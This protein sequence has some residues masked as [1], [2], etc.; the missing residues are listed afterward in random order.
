MTAASQR[1][2]QTIAPYFFVGDIIRAAEYYR[3]K[4]G[5]AFDRYWGDPPGFVIVYR[6][7]VHV[8]LRAGHDGGR[9][10]PNRTLDEHAWDAYIWVRDANAMHEELKGRLAMIT[11]SPNDTFYGC[12]EFE[13]CDLDGHIICF[14]QVLENAGS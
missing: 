1:D 9:P 2:L 11:R 4:L 5:F 8:M 10:H 6:D 14:G 13:V 12:W 3:D 7:G